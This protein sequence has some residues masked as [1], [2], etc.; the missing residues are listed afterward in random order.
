MLHPPLTG[1]HPAAEAAGMRGDVGVRHRSGPVVAVLGGV[2]VF[3]M[4]LTIFSIAALSA[5]R[6]YVGGESLYSKGQKDAQ[7]YLL[8]YLEFRREEDYRR[9][10]AALVVPLGDRAAR[11]ALERPQPDRAA[12]QAGFL[13]GG[14]DPADIDGLIWLF[15]WFHTSHFMAEPIARWTEGDRAIEQ[16]QAL[17]ATAHARFAARPDAPPAGDLRAQAAV[18]NDR[19]TALESAFAARLTSAAREMEIWLLGTNLAAAAVLGAAGLGFV[20]QSLRERAAAEAE[21]RRR[22]ELLRQ[23]LDSV[24]DAV[25]TMDAQGRI[26]LFNR[27]AE[28]IFRARASDCIGRALS[29]LFA[30]A[31][32]PTLESLL[33]QSHRLPDA[34]V[35]IG[36]VHELR[37][38]RADGTEFPA[39]MSISRLETDD[40][41]LVTLILRDVSEQALVRQERQARQALEE[42]SRAKS[43]FVSRMSHELRTP[44]NAVLGFARLMI[45]DT[46]RPLDSQH[47]ARVCHIE[48]AGAHL[49]DLV[50][51]ILDLSRVESGEMALSP[52]TFDV[53]PVIEEAL[54]FVTELARD[55]GVLLDPQ[56]ALEPV[57][58]AAPAGT[59]VLA[60][61]VRLRQVLANLLS[62]AVKYTPRGGL[63]RL[64]VRCG[65][66]LCD[67]RIIDTGIGMNP[68]QLSHLFE[69]FNRLGAENSA[70][71]GTGI[72]LVL[73]R[74]LVGLMG[75]ELVIESARGEGTIATV[76]LQRR[77]L[78]E[79]PAA[80]AP[81]AVAVP[82]PEGRT[83]EVLYAEDN[84]VNVEL[85]QQVARLR[86]GVSLHI[87]QSGS[88]ALRL[89]RRLQP[90][91]MLV[92]MQLGDMTGM[93]V[94]A[95][96]RADPATEDI[97]LVALSADALPEQIEA[98][99]AGGFEEYLT[100]PINFVEILRV[101][102]AHS[103]AP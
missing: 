4:A 41:G 99:L 46:G 25:V 24:A 35:E 77:L 90:R 30:P 89:A 42:T 79:A 98:A 38:V 51:D 2:I 10:S 78:A 22:Q 96:L 39:E 1:T 9:F 26:V 49:L 5:V 17:A 7:V 11:E 95:L 55:G 92:D 64:S 72:G 47:L 94:A 85:L 65:D 48:R 93:E 16:M 56:V 70:I 87:A 6:A 54:A 32:Q 84:E 75:G 8:D 36:P 101:L 50:N 29:S 83:L 74:H 102:A 23:L 62:N 73:T 37:G 13:A 40:G 103:H 69:P 20:R 57:D 52:A 15:R 44:L 82:E 19:L 80:L 3:Q 59:L 86:P 66:K 43:Q 67:I 31:S 88:E 27:A 53:V 12:A 91:L 28:T 81:L 71:E 21:I 34:G 97:H 45:M 63:V 18:L 61:R 60:D 76:R 14:N 100:K 68:E 33:A 58:P